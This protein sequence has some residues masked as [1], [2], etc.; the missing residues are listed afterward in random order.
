LS[1]LAN[2]LLAYRFGPGFA[3]E[4]QLVGALERIESGGVL[5][6]LDALFVGREA[7]TWELVAVSLTVHGSGG[8]I[9][10]LLG[11]RL[12]AEERRAAT[13]RAV[14]GAGGEAVGELGSLLSPGA[15]IAVALVEHSWARA[16]DEA[17]AR[18]G[19]AEVMSESVQVGQIIEFLPQLRAVIEK[20]E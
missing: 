20:T 19:G 12:D 16:L 2:Q 3:F 11:F 17:I 10:K 13:R 8:M 18:T 14:E 7:E 1:P 4:G 9:G 15:A 6:I 5:R